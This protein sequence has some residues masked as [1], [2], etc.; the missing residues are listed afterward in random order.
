MHKTHYS[1]EVLST[2]SRNNLH[3]SFVPAKLTWALQPADTHVFAG[4]KR[5]LCQRLEI[6]AVHSEDGKIVGLAYHKA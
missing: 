2:C 5:R 1:P 4:Q 6:M 3:V